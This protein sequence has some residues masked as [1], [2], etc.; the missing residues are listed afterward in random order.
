MISSLECKPS[1]TMDQV[2]EYLQYTWSQKFTVHAP[3]LKKLLED[4]LHQAVY[5]KQRI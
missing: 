3:F 5:K 4:V 1:Q 2:W